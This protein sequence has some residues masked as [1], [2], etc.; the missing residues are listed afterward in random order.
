[1]APDPDEFGGMSE[2]D[3]NKWDSEAEDRWQAQHSGWC[4]EPNPYGFDTPTVWP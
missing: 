4:E 3:Y 2:E 1:M